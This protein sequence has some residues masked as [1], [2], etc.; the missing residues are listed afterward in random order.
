VKDVPPVYPAIARDARIQG[1]V[2]LECTIDPQGHVRELR[3][4]RGVPLLDEAARAA[5][6]QWVY[7]PTLLNGVPVAVVMN[8]TVTFALR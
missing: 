3:V 4:V 6:A 7:K 1:E 5:V 8:V 2:V